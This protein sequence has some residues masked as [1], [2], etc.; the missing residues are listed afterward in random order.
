MTVLH[1]SPRHAAYLAALLLSC[2]GGSALAQSIAGQT[3]S[4]AGPSTDNGASYSYLA[5]QSVDAFQFSPTLTGDVALVPGRMQINAGAGF[6]DCPGA[7]GAQVGTTSGVVTVTCSDVPN[8]LGGRQKRINV[9]T[10]NSSALP[11]RPL[12]TPTCSSPYAVYRFDVPAR[13]NGGT[14]T[15]GVGGALFSDN[16][17]FVNGG[18][19]PDGTLTITMTAIAPSLAYTPSPGTITFPGGNSGTTQNASITVTASGGSGSGSVSLSCNAPG[20][21]FTA[22][23]LSQSNL[24]IGDAATNISLQCVL[25][26]TQQNSTLSCTETSSPGGAIPRQWP[27]VCPAANQPAYAS[28]PRPSGV[29]AAYG[30]LLSPV[31]STTISVTNGGT[32][33]L[34]VTPCSF[35]AGAPFALSRSGFSAGTLAPGAS[36]QLVIDCTAPAPGTSLSTTLTCST[37]DPNRDSVLYPVDC[38]APP[39]AAPGTSASPAPRLSSPAP[40]AGALLGSAAAVATGPDPAGTSLEEVVVVGAPEGGDG[41]RAY[42]YVRGAASFAALSEAKSSRESLGALVAVLE[43]PALRGGARAKAIGDKFGTGVAISDSGTT[44]AIG[45]P[46]AGPADQGSVFVYARPVGGWS[47]LDAIVPVEIAAPAPGAVAPDDFGAAVQFTPEGTLV[48]GAPLADV[49]GQSDAGAAWVFRDNAGAWMPVAGALTAGSPSS[50][51]SFGAALAANDGLVA[52]GA[53]GEAGSTGALY[54][55]PDNAGAPGAQARVQ[56]SGAIA[57]DKFGASIA[58][59]GGIIASGSPGDDTAAGNDSGSVTLLLQGAGTATTE[60]GMLLP[61]VGAGQLAGSAVASNG[62]VILVGAPLAS[63]PGGS[64][65]TANGGR[66]YVY[67]L[68]ESLAASEL[69]DG[70]YENAIGEAGDRFG[71]AIAIGARLAVVGAPMTDEAADVDEGRAD[72]FRLDG[73]FRSDMAR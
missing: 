57:G 54:L 27:L 67:E 9:S 69:P 1:R 15:L 29:A 51:A 24:F 52:V 10:S 58:I 14:A 35:G 66:A 28:L 12:C 21:P 8:G 62:N 16:G 36:G 4:Y 13:R 22:S 18:S 72:P 70:F 55:H 46:S 61:D 20:A 64:G 53:P 68:D 41:G 37:N 42:V 43:P 63:A 59:A 65:F 32:A 38:V 33:T 2:V 31:A 50:G 11:S 26:P 17:V 5:G 45:A 56:P 25:G 3:A 39:L 19:N 44:I 71:T 49:S 7:F 40:D 47:N 34:S 73:I 60:A 23:P 6:V 48:V 30:S